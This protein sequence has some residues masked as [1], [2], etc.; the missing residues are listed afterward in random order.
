[1]PLFTDLV[2]DAIVVAKVR[3][4]ETILSKVSKT[5]I[6]DPK[7]L[8]ELKQSNQNRPWPALE[9]RIESDNSFPDTVTMSDSILRAARK[10]SHRSNMSETEVVVYMYVRSLDFS[11][12]SKEF[13]NLFM[14]YWEKA[15]G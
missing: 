10:V 13:L 8:A 9:A 7:T 5:H 6:V 2:E 12:E 11:E 15:L 1:M 14:S 4:G 3:F